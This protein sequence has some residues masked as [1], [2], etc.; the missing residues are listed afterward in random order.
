MSRAL[1]DH[2]LKSEKTGLIGEPFVS[3][4]VLLN[5]DD[6]HIILAS[7]ALWDMISGQEACDMMRADLNAE[8]LA[9][10]LM[11]VALKSTDNATVIVIVL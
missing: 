4:A 1:G 2:F 7:D 6:S 5:S 10:M 11:E 3:D 9:R 8:D